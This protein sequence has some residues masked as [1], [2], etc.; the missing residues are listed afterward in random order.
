[1]SVVTTPLQALERY[2]VG[3]WNVYVVEAP[4]EMSRDHPEIL[5]QCVTVQWDGK[6][7]TF[8]VGGVERRLPMHPI[9]PGEHIGLAEWRTS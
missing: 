4:F 9:R 6:T 8:I 1:M 2:E 3:P 7:R 5:N